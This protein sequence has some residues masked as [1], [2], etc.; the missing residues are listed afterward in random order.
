LLSYLRGAT[1]HVH[2]QTYVLGEELFGQRSL[3]LGDWKLLWLDPPEGVGAWQLYDLLGNRAETNDLIALQ[4][5]IAAELERA[6]QQYVERNG[7]ILSPFPIGLG[8]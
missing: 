6:W 8:G 3:Q 7:V 2:D 1:K 5:A 4:P